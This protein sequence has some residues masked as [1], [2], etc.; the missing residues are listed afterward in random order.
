ME[1]KDK[2]EIVVKGAYDVIVVGG[3]IAGV[4]AAVTAARRGAAVMLLEK[5]VNLGGLATNGLISWYEPLCDGK[6]RKVMGGMAEELLQLSIAYGFD[7][8]PPKW[9]GNGENA[10]KNERYS[11]YF[12]PAVFSLALDELIRKNEVKLRYDTYAVYPV[13]EGGHCSGVICE[14]A[15]GREFFGA[16]VLIDATGDATIAQRAG[17]PTV[18]GENYMTYIVHSFDKNG[19]AKLEADGDI[20]SFRQWKNAGSDMFGNGHPNNMKKLSWITAEEVTEYM[21]TGKKRML[22]RIKMLDRESFDIMSLPFMP[23]LRTIRHIVGKKEFRAD[24]EMEFL[25]SI[26]VCGEY[27]SS[28][29]GNHYQVPF[30]ALYHENVDNLLAAGRIISAP[31]GDGW[32]VARVIPVCALTGEAAGN[33]A[34]LAVQEGCSIPEITVEKLQALQE[35]SGNLIRL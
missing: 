11:T 31:Q 23:Q 18:P 20:C 28:G 24:T 30:G 35:S 8:L 21:M 32:E 27:R 4:A 33:A 16:K 19:A 14:S 6:G 17:V 10:P 7:N 2:R 13:T 9:G 15:S 12:S 5:S 34:Y 29:I 1:I 22:D 25:D 26:G 3:G